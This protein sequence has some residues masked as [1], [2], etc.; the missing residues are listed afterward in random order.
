MR[1]SD[2]RYPDVKI[3]LEA[4]GSVI[5]ASG[6]TI[7]VLP[8]VIFGLISH[9]GPPALQPPAEVAERVRVRGRQTRQR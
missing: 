8:V 5:G 3:T 9:L 6:P 2:H 1:S 7:V 4:H